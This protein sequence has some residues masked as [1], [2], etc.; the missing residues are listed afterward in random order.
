MYKFVD[1]S[2]LKMF[3]DICKLLKEKLNVMSDS[4]KKV[5][6]LEI[7]TIKNELNTYKNADWGSIKKK[8]LKDILIQN[9]LIECKKKYEIGD[10]QIKKLYNLI[11]LG[12]MLKSI[13]ST[14]VIYENGVITDINGINFNKGKYIVTI[15]IYSALE[16]DNSCTTKITGKKLLK[17]L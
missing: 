7:Q 5:M 11:N 9:Y 17:D 14:D 6:Y 2:D 3:Q 8:G 1:K 13:D 16:E 4:D 15:D 10:Y 12:I